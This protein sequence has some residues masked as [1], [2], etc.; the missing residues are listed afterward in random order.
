MLVDLPNWVGDQMMA[1]P[2]L[3]RLV[4]GNRGGETVLHTR[5][6][7]VRFLSSLFPDI[8]VMASP[9]KCSPVA[10]ARMLCSGG[11]FKVG[12]TLRNAARAKILVRL[13][14]RWST[15]SRGEGAFMLLSAPRA[16]D[17]GRH[18]VHD[19]DAVLT[20][21]GLEVADPGARPVLPP[22]LR[23]EGE[24]LLRRAGVDRKRAIGLAPATARG[25]AK[26]WP[27]EWFGELARRLNARGWKPV[28]V[29]GPGE[30][31]VAGSVASAARS[32]LPV[33]GFDRDVAGLAAVV[34]S[35]R[36]LVCN[37]SGPMQVAALFGTPAVAIF[38]SSDPCRTAPLGDRHRVLS[39]AIACAP[40][41]ALGCPLGH[42]GCMRRIEVDTVEAA[43]LAALVEIDAT[44]A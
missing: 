9:R 43:T 3:A 27:V 41:F 26:R 40:C 1:M 22:S 16:V 12:V 39:A 8:S 25:D 31:A 29:I 23:E 24:R 13:A 14:S 36:L 38:G 32:D 42:H 19:A 28:V 34:G 33:L 4:E 30:E 37:D 21:L 7:M 35:L 2:A 44:G 6:S 15:G 11:R 20:A 17:R 10:S 18:Q 5:P